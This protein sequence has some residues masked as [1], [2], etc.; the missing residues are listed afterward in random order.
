MPTKTPATSLQEF[1]RDATFPLAKDE[2]VRSAREAGLTSD[3][4]S[5]LERL[6]QETYMTPVDVSLAVSQLDAGSTAGAKGS[7]GSRR[8][9]TKAEPAASAQDRASGQAKRPPQPVM[10]PNPAK[11]EMTGATSRIATR[12]TGIAKDQLELRKGQ[13]TMQLE[14]AAQSIRQSSEQFRQQ[15]NPTLA[16]VSEAAASGLEQANEFL[17]TRDV[18]AVIGEAEAT[19][20]RQPALVI[21][22]GFAIAFLVT[23]ML[24]AGVSEPRID[25]QPKNQNER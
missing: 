14:Q 18:D 20:R 6:P 25:D 24:K 4:V 15:G 11:T 5:T 7:S 16:D 8:S 23:R 3:M 2:L 13:A 12:V 10:A 1:L 21:G 19:A 22:G 17:R 9:T